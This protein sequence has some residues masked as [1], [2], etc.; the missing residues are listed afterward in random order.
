MNTIPN[1]IFR[2]ALTSDLKFFFE[3]MSSL[4]GSYIDSFEF[5]VNYKSKIGNLD[6]ILFVIEDIPGTDPDLI[7]SAVGII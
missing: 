6:F 7:L 4:E 1:Y 2:K 3:S 5:E